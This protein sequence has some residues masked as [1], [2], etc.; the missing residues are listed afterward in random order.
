MV[1]QPQKA[2]EDL[3][4]HVGRYREE[5]FHFICE[6]LSQ[7]AEALHGPEAVVH[8]EVHE[9]LAAADIDWG[10]LREL[11]EVGDLPPEL[12]QAIDA[13]GGFD[14]L[15]RHVT[16][17]QLCWGLRDVALKRWGMLART[18]LESWDVRETDDFGRIVFG[19]IE[20]DMMQKQPGDSLDDFKDVYDF[21]EAFDET[22]KS[23]GHDDAD[24]STDE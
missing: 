5:A 12:L 6:G 9:Y 4:K 2:F 13:A 1:D 7:V 3:V 10:E 15:N 23:I 8:R 11:Y 14:K 24:V 22:F 17:R 20:C 16:G 19:F 21:K 18:V